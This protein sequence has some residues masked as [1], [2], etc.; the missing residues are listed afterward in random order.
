MLAVGLWLAPPLV[1]GATEAELIR[2]LDRADRELAGVTD[3]TAVMVSQERIGEVLQPVERVQVKFQRPFRVYM[4][5]ID[6]PSKGR[7]GLYVAGAHNGKFLVYEPK[8]IQRLFTTALDPADKRV[9]EKSRH[10]VTD[11]GIGRLLEIIQ[12][13]TGRATRQGVLRVVD[14]GPGEIGGRRVRQV[15]GVLPQDPGAGYYAYRVMLAFDED[16]SLPIRIV[17]H[18]WQNRLVED[19]TY[20]DLRL[21]PGL[22]GKDFDPANPEYGF[23]SWKLQISAR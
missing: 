21:N 2:L 20:V 10:P 11:M 14:R 16:H 4:R 5:W 7:E 22:N 15:E 19:Y 17:A 12:E 23:S 1:F 6:G 18:D 13:N 3:Y 9:M 8:G